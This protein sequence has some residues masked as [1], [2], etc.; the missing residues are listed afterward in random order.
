[1]THISESN[2]DAQMA[3]PPKS[4]AK[5]LSKFMAC[6]VGTT[7][8]C[9]SAYALSVNSLVQSAKM[10]ATYKWFLLKE[11]PGPRIIF[12]SGSNSHHAIDTD[13]VGAALGMSAINIADNGGYPIEDKITRLETYARAGDIVVLPLEWTFYHREKLTD[14][15]VETL[16]TDNRDYYQSMPAVKRAQR[17][18]SLPPEKII[19]AF[20]KKK[21]RPV[22]DVESPAKDLFVAALT[23]STGHQSRKVSIGPELGVAEQSCDDYILGKTAQRKNLKLSANIKPALARLKK[24]KN[25]GIG[26]HFAWPVL[27]GDGCMSDPAYVTGFRAQIEQAVNLAGFEFLGTPGQ[28]LYGQNLQDNTPYHVVTKGTDIHTQKMIGFLQAQGYGETGSPLDIKT[29][30]RH[31]LLEMELASIKP[32][33][34]PALP[35]G[36]PIAM[37]NPEMRELVEF[38]AGWWD[39]EPYGRWMR[40]NRAMFRVTLPKDI[41]PKSVL[42]IQGSTKSGQPE[43]VS[44]SI[45]GKVISSGMFGESAPLLVPAADLPRGEALS[46]FLSLPEADLPQSPLELGENQD[47][48]SMTLHLHSLELTTSEAEAEIEQV[49]VSNDAAPNATAIKTVPYVSDNLVFDYTQAFLD[50]GPLNCGPADMKRNSIPLKISFSEG[51]WEQENYGRWMKDQ[52]ATLDITMPDNGEGMPENRYSIRLEGDFFMN[53]VQSV[54]AVIDGKKLNPFTLMADGSLISIFESSQMGNSITLE[55]ELSG[56]T[57]QSPKTLGLSQDDRTLTYFLKSAQ[58]IPA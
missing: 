30:A 22:Q 8:I 55:L 3:T 54:S 45:N 14:N 37:D 21:S 26:I 2:N 4:A 40:D 38:S 49:E 32:L 18:L 39:F 7:A 12:E 16:F 10:P 48:R 46:I 13:A 24:L 15:Y 23:Q 34:Q 42:K 27:A 25:K 29:F 1:M 11:V 6:L 28:S 43:K 35:I 17:A 47:A 52:R 20:S 44:L 41:S 33:N 56:K 51:W 5:Q 9:L 19:K 31:R 53:R 50:E 57:T 36:K 58:L